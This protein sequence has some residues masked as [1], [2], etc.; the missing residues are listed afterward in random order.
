MNYGEKS[1]KVHEE[2]IGKVEVVSKIAVTNK[3]ELSIA[4]TPG[5]AEPCRKIH[6]NKENVYKYT[7]KGNLVAVVSDG[8]AVLG[9]GDIGP[10]AS[11]PVMEGKSVLFKEFANV[12]AF[13]ICLATKDID[14]IVKT[15]KYLEPTFGGINLEDI[16]SPRC[17]EIEKRLKDEL[18]IPVFHDDQHGTAIVVSAGLIN[19]LKLTGKNIEDATI[20]VNGPGAAGTAIVKMLVNLGAKDIIV[21]DRNGILCKEN[22]SLKGH[23]KELAKM[24]NINGKQ[25]VLKDALEGADVFIGVS[26]AN[27][28]NQEM[29]KSMN[30]DAIVFAMAN[31]TPEIMPDLAIEA[32][33]R[34]VGTGRSDFPNQ[35]NNVLAFPGI[36]RGALNVRARGIN[37]E[38]K[39]AAAYAIAGIIS[40]KELKEDYVIPN[41]FDKKIVK[42]VADAV[43]KAAKETGMC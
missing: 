28:V 16:S 17:F 37:E 40:D 23:K 5:V 35:I 42:R 19:A 39:L 8:T 27:I 25:G 10:Q 33:A 24:T 31:P 26:A 20:V 36:F 13:P 41:P 21:C 1:L 30:K 7:S 12:D 32:G 9:L 38:M 6:D 4:Y 34:V 29:I 11:I 18:N 14:Q 15:V 22:N 3:E 43:A 2:K